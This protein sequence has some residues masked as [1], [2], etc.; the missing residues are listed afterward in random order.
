MAAPKRKTR[1]LSPSTGDDGAIRL[2]KVLASAGYGS[3]RH[4][5]EFIQSGRVTVDGETVTELGFRVDPDHQK[6]QV[7]G[8]NISLERKVY[9]VLNKP[10]GYLCTN[11]DPAG[12][13]RVIDLFPK[14][15]QRLFT[16]GRLDEN[17]EGL[18]LVTNDGEFANCLAHPRYSVPRVYEV[19][20]AG[21]PN[22][23]AIRAMREGLRF[24]EG[25]FRVQ[26]A[27]RVRVKGK[28]AVLQLTL[29]Q[30]RNREIRRMLARIGHKVMK[31]RRVQFGPIR[32][33]RVGLGEHRA[34]KPA[35]VK[36]LKEL[37]EEPRTPRST[38]RSRGGGTKKPQRKTTG[39]RR[40]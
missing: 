25:T 4:C 16:V 7:D 1:N 29:T 3:R 32:L 30:G 15:K 17:S 6:I 13:R 36:Q 39:K 10:T 21:I 2:Q 37:L 27:K 38:R 22:Q 18:L 23:E 12:R 9:Y 31:L 11:A 34:L 33:G 35:E 8:E 26:R 5:E 20:V 28:S 14:T 40:R 19:Q 24:S